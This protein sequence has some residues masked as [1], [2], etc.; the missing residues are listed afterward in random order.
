MG[1]EEIGLLVISVFKHFFDHNWV[2]RDSLGGKL[3]DIWD[4]VAFGKGMVLKKK[5]TC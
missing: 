1:S 2:F 5:A 3:S 4:F